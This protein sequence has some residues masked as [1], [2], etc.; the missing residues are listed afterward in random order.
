VQDIDTTY[1][2]SHLGLCVTDLER[3]MRFYCEGIGFEPHMRFHITR[4]IAEVDPPVDVVAQFIVLGALELELLHYASPGTIGRP[5]ERRNHLGL[6]HLS[7]VVDDVER[8][9]LELEALGGTILQ[10]TRNPTEDPESERILF[11]AD[12]DGTR[13]ELMSIP[14]NHPYW[15]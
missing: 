4:Q 8:R 7:F 3:S 6:T 10:D 9:A 15:G 5:H 2:P 13:V 12:P 14:P 1:K 11:V